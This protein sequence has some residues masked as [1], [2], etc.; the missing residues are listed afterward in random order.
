MFLG[1][2]LGAAGA[3]TDPQPWHQS[4]INQPST[5][6]GFHESYTLASINPNPETPQ[7]LRMMYPVL[8]THTRFLVFDFWR[9]AGG[10]PH[11][12]SPKVADSSYKKKERLCFASSS[13]GSFA[14]GSSDDVSET[15][16]LLQLTEAS[17][18]Q[19]LR[20]MYP[21][22]GAREGP[23]GRGSCRSSALTP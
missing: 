10:G 15:Q 21:F 23:C 6:N 18:P 12:F 7:D 2:I 17:T 3:S 20:M 1:P 8:G 4:S 9:I 14:A 16:L 19:D 11:N 13:L 5:L 22:T